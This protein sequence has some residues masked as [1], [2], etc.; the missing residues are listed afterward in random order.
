[1]RDNG[2]FEG[3]GQTL[4]LLSKL[5]KFSDTAGANL[6]RRTLLGVLK[7]PISYSM[8]F[9]PNL[10]PRLDCR[11]S[12]IKIIDRNASK[13]PKC[14]MDSEQDVVNWILDPLNS[15]DRS[16]FCARKE[17]SEKHHDAI[18]KSLDC[19]IMDLADDISFGVHDLED[20]L[21]LKLVTEAEFRQFVPEEACSDFL[22][23]LKEKY[24]NEF[25]NNVYDQWVSYL[26]GE[27][28]KR[29]R[30]IGRL[31]HHFITNCG[32]QTEDGFEEPLLRFRVIQ[33]AA[34]KRFLTCLKDLVREEVI[35]SAAVQHLE[36]KGQW[37]VISTFEVLYSDPQKF[38]PRDTLERFNERAQSIRV[39]CDHIAG[40]TDSFLLKTYDRLFSPHMGSVFDRL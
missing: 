29:K 31:V 40:M 21:A 3:N 19:S 34:A 22:T 18:H 37:M 27:G 12:S 32:F 39:I 25:A 20:A 14:Y 15:T 6:C 17:N 4:R 10:A 9:N 36:F 28:H 35:F 5:E 1:M 38:L 13:P 30:N 7:Y 26:F 33:S 24:K 16:L 2:G 11:P 23:A 8:A